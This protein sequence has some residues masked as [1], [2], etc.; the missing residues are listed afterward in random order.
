M[1]GKII[2]SKYRGERRFT[3]KIIFFCLLV[4]F[5][6]GF[7][8]EAYS[9]TAKLE[10][11]S[12]PSAVVQG[13]PFMLVILGSQNVRDVK[14]LT[15]DGKKQN[16]VNY[17]NLLVSLVPTDLYQLPGKYF[18]KL[19]DKN[20][21]NLNTSVTVVKRPKVEAP[22]GIPEKLGGN[23]KKAQD[24]VIA[25]LA[26]EK[27]ILLGLG[28][29]SKNYWQKPFTFPVSNPIVTDSYGYSRIT[30][31]YSIAHKGTDFRAKEGTKVYAMN[32]GIVKYASDLGIYGNT[33]VIDHGY[34][35]KTMYM[36]MSKILVEK[37][38][39]V[40]IGQKIALSGSTGYAESPHLHLSIWINDI[41]IDPMKFMSLFGY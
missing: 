12:I 36:H 39:M 41:S 8:S 15:F 16:I 19:V 32:D 31:Q 1:L 14:S 26:S 30:G 34:G 24:A 29:E 20:G 17:Q 23:T 27:E 6:L 37:G 11:I 33:V 25:S 7:S 13:E 38:Q 40:K 35:L 10:L 4:L 5:V 22:L 18:I 3:S 21:K 2:K 9:A 28:L